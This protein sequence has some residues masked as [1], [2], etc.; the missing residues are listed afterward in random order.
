MTGP[1]GTGKGEGAGYYRAH[2][3]CCVNERPDGHARG[4]CKA[5]GGVRL[6]NYMKARVKELG[7]DGVRVNQAGCLDRCELGPVLV[8]YPEGVWYRY[9]TTEDVDEIIREHLQ[10]GRPVARLRLADDQTALGPDDAVA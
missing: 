10:A 4:C 9:E 7:L 2:L 3:F 6:R 1:V 5:K 8:V